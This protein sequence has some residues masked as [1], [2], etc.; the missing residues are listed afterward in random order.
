[1]NFNPAVSP[2]NMPELSW[3]YGYPAVLAVMAIVGGG[4]L[5]Y[6]RRKRWL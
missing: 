3:K 4:M 5:L 6:F 1:M 2:W